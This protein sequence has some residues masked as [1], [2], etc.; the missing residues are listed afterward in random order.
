M[1]CFDANLLLEVVFGRKYSNLVV[2]YLENTKEP[3][4]I[5]ALT[6]HLVVHF[7]KKE[8]HI[9]VLREFLQDFDMLSLEKTDFEWAFNNMRNDDFEDALQLAVAI[10]HG[11]KK[12][13]TIDNEL[14]LKYKNLQSI[15]VELLK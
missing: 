6:G 3:I 4:G 1:I 10:R 8:R 7:G 11:C 13:T 2:D 9:P 12:F 5:S 14:F 15:K